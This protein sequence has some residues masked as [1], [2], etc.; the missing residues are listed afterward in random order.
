MDL[1]VALQHL[2]GPEIAR[3]KHVQRG[4]LLVRDRIAELLDPHS[5]FLELSSFAGY[6]LYKEQVPAGG[7]VTGIGRVQG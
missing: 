6:N 5:P 2:G 3:H 7:V 4:K 1:R